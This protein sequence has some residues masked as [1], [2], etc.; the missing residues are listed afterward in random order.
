MTH[1]PVRVDDDA[2][3]WDVVHT[4]VVGTQTINSPDLVAH[5]KQLGPPRSRIATR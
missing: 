2:V 5:L 3:R 1:I 4:L